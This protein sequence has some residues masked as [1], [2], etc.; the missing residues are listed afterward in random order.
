[1]T[2]VTKRG[3]RGE[4]SLF[5]GERVLK[6]SS[7]PDAYGT[8]DEANSFLGLVRAKTENPALK[9]TIL[10][11]QKLLF[12]LNSELACE[13]EHLG[14]LQRLIE[15]RD[16][17]YLESLLRAIEVTVQ[18]PG[19]FI[20]YGE[21]EISALLD[22]ARAII[23]RAERRIIGMTNAT[24]PIRPEILTFVNRLSDLLYMLAREEDVRLG[25]VWESPDFGAQP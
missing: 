4:T 7:R 21:T 6:S 11:I 19:R 20:I 14:R 1:M 9:A 25:Q 18:L 12:V 8:V 15:S 22:I 23:R 13:P 2:I 17:E 3:D 5:S 24:S 10:N 16:I